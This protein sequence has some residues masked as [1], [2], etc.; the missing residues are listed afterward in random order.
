MKLT[1]AQRTLL[2]RFAKGDIVWRVLRTTAHLWTFRS[3]AYRGFIDAYNDP[4]RDEVWSITE[5]GRRALEES[6]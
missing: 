4:Y 6:R 2:S 1:E 5:A 3:L